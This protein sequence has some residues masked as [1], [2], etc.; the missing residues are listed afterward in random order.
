MYGALPKTLIHRFRRKTYFIRL[1]LSTSDYA[2]YQLFL[3]TCSLLKQRSE[4]N[5]VFVTALATAATWELTGRVCAAPPD[6]L[7]LTGGTSRFG[8]ID[9]YIAYQSR[10]VRVPDKAAWLLVSEASEIFRGTPNIT[11][12]IPLLI[13]VG[14][15]QFDLLDVF[16]SMVLGRPESPEDRK[17][18][19]QAVE[20]N[21]AAL[22]QAVAGLSALANGRP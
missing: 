18:F 22:T 12:M 7:F 4:E 15:L 13:W 19:E 20:R 17:I 3:N 5:P 1:V 11:D 2:V 6:E 8:G 21:V 16:G 10:E 9:K 14:S